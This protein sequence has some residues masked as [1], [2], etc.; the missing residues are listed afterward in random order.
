MNCPDIARLLDEKNVDQILATEQ[1]D[2]HL[3][4]TS[5]PACARDWHIHAQ[6]VAA[7]I[8]PVPDELRRQFPKQL[9]HSFRSRLRWRKSLIAIGAVAAMATAAAMLALRQGSQAPAVTTAGV[10]QA[11]PNEVQDPRE[12][13]PLPAGSELSNEPRSAEEQKVVDEWKRRVG[14]W[15][16]LR[17]DPDALITAA[18]LLMSPPGDAQEFRSLLQRAVA[19]APNSARIHATAV[20]LCPVE[21]SCDP[22]PYERALRRVAPDNAMGWTGEVGRA[23]RSGDNAAFQWALTSMAQARTFDMYTNATMLAVT[24]QIL[25]A[26]VAAPEMAHSDWLD[27]AIEAASAMPIPEI[28]PIMNACKASTDANMLFECHRI[29]AAMRAG[30]DVLFNTL[31]VRLSASGLPAESAEALALEHQW[32]QIQWLSRKA[33]WDD[34]TSF[35]RAIADHPRQLDAWRAWLEEHGIPTEP[36]ADWKP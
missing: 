27:V 19:L 8:P 3:H 21:P 35:L 31:G 23:S 6:L 13:L 10:E 1:Q 18:I 12:L 20:L 29:G 16:A 30:D 14:M 11:K 9:A 28:R 36:P 24:S 5:C 33:Q 32:R 4:L 15:L 7:A 25:A 17:D 26:R 2:L 22:K 34:P